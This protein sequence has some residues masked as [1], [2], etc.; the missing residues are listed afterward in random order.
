MAY[1]PTVSPARENAV[2]EYAPPYI[3]DRYI[4]DR[5]GAIFLL[6]IAVGSLNRLAPRLARDWPG[7]A[8]AVLRGLSPSGES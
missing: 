4:T 3:A 7:E 5:E 8:L 2:G 1:S 6:M